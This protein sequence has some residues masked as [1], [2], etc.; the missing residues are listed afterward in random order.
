ML[1]NKLFFELLDKRFEKYNLKNKGSIKLLTED[2]KHF[3]MSY[4]TKGGYSVD[5][6]LWVLETD[7]EFISDY[8]EMYNYESAEIL[9]QWFSQK[10]NLPVDNV[11]QLIPE[12]VKPLSINLIEYGV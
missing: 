1:Q 11:G 7:V 6:N 8:F 2:N 9:S 3:R 10:Y 4:E 12:Y 5:N